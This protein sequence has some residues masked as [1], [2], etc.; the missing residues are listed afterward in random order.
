MIQIETHLQNLSL[1]F[2]DGLIDPLVYKSIGNY[3]LC[4]TGAE[5]EDWDKYEFP[6]E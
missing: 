4:K 6:Y 5:N 1:I 2:F 3:W